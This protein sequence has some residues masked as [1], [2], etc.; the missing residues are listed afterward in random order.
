M[1]EYLK[2][3][4]ATIKSYFKFNESGLCKF[5]NNTSTF[6]TIFR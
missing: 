2:H 1:E 5:K 3:F 6:M 4:I